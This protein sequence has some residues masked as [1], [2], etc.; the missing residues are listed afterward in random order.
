MASNTNINIAAA[1][2]ETPPL[3]TLTD[4]VRTEIDLAQKLLTTIQ[5]ERAALIEQH[6]D[7]VNQLGLAKRELSR[8]LDA[9]GSK[10]DRLLN[11]WGFKTGSS[12]TAALLE[13]HPDRTLADA[14]QTLRATATLCKQENS[15]V[16][17]AIG[18]HLMVANQAIQVLKS[19]AKPSE[20][21]YAADGA[22][23]AR[24]APQTLA[25]I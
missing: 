13:Q 21:L 7:T 19:G 8:A 4:I 6:T 22:K 18:K 16:G 12:G 17:I 10:R 24:T 1:S 14:W 25:K 11:E 23:T 5:N 9:A 3:T 15:L 20:Q 2:G